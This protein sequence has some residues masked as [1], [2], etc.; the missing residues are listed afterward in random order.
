MCLSFN[1]AIQPHQVNSELHL[2]G[3]ISCHVSYCYSRLDWKFA[4]NTLPLSIRQTSIL[5][6]ASTQMAPCLDITTP[7]PR[8]RKQAPTLQCAF[9]AL[10]WPFS[11]S[12]SKCYSCFLSYQAT[13]LDCDTG[14]MSFRHQRITN[15]EDMEEHTTNV[16]ANLLEKKEKAQSIPG[17]PKCIVNCTGNGIYNALG[18]LTVVKETGSKPGK[19]SSPICCPILPVQGTQFPINIFTIL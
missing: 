10:Y 7:P 4:W 14:I 13:Q 2:L 18:S 12:S 8:P 19:N 16:C 9:K 15:L 11:A 3:A 1:P 6:R 17:T 5:L